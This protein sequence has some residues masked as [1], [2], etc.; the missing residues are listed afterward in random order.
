MRPLSPADPTLGCFLPRSA[1]H[2]RAA[3]W[4]SQGLGRRLLPVSQQGESVP[5]RA[6]RQLCPEPGH[7]Q[8]GM[9]DIHCALC[10]GWKG[11]SSVCGVSRLS[12]PQ[13]VPLTVCITIDNWL[14]FVSQLYFGYCCSAVPPMSPGSSC[15]RKPA[16][17]WGPGACTL[18]LPSAF[19]VVLNFVHVNVYPYP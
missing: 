15:C 10:C 1:L 2:I 3:P 6:Q 19:T 11:V 7:C 4:Q 17:C 14:L 12:R 13:C 5:R 8:A 9:G 18:G 16:L